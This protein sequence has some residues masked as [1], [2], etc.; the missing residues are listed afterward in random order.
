MNRT[1]RNII[2]LAF[3]AFAFVVLLATW[4]LWVIQ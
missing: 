4:T 1:D 3:A 2:L